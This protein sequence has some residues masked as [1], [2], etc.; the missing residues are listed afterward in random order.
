MR[1]MLFVSLWFICA[2]NVF[3]MNVPEATEQGIVDDCHLT[4]E[5]S[6]MLLK[7]KAKTPPEQ[8]YN[9]A[10][11]MLK[12][13]GYKGSFGTVDF[14]ASMFTGTALQMGPEVDNFMAAADQGDLELMVS[15]HEMDCLEKAMTEFPSKTPA[16]AGRPK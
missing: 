16:G 2:G 8:L 3:A 4:A 14:I 10:M 12:E 1:T 9:A 6:V 13:K 11:K 5:L 7:M 15:D